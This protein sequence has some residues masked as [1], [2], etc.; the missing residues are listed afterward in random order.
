[1]QRNKFV[2]LVYN[3]ARIMFLLLSILY[4]VS[5]QFFDCWQLITEIVFKHII[6]FKTSMQ[7]T[8]ACNFPFPKFVEGVV[9]GQF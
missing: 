3:P 1:M 6:Q 9:K 2:E 7:V 4:Y 5:I 8:L